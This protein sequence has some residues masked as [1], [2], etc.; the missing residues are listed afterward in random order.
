MEI[1][2]HDAKWNSM[3]NSSPNIL[4]KE[5]CLEITHNTDTMKKKFEKEADEEAESEEFL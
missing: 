4:V 2:A 3:R 5:N 1:V